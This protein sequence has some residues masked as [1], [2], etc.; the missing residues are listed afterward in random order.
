MNINMFNTLGIVVLFKDRGA[1]VSLKVNKW[2]NLQPKLCM[3]VNLFANFYRSSAQTMLA[4]LK[5]M[6]E[7][8][9]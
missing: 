7:V 4:W 2:L 5:L 1:G 6:S 8:E 3:T 9:K